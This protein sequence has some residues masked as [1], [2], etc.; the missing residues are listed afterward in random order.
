MSYLQELREARE[1]APVAYHDFALHTREFPD[2]LFC[3]F[4]GKDHPYYVP[5]I[6]QFTDFYQ[7]F[8]C[9]NK[10]KV[11]AV[12]RLISL[13]REYDRY[14][15]A[16]FV[17]RDFQPSLPPANPPIYETPCY[18]IENLYVS[19]EVFAEILKNHFQLQEGKAEFQACMQRYRERQAS[20]HQAC[21]LLNAWYACLIEVR[22]REGT[23]TGVNLTDQLPKGFVQIGLE[24]V[25]QEYD[26]QTIQDTFPK[27]PQISEEVVQEKMAAFP[28]EE[29]HHWFRG[30]YELGFLL[31]M[32]QLL[33]EDARGPKTLLEQ[34]VTSPFSDKLSIAQ[35]LTIFS[36]YAETP[37]SLLDYLREVCA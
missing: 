20:F 11:L 34:K 3:F 9:G 35:A 4:E 7:V 27:A 21:H 31:T 6:K 28:L 17:D 24:S 13:H 1:G 37:Q 2:H 29:A 32:I 33:L 8:A 30:K 5:R 36:P 23:H 14:R 10:A 18:S 26:W 15:K 16:F 12:H 19:V 25:S 22:E